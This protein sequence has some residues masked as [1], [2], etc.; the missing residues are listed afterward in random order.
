[1]QASKAP[2]EARLPA[3]LTRLPLIPFVIGLSSEISVI[4]C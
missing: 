4:R 3:A 2:P 1:M